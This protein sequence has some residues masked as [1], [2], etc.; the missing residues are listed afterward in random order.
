M[1]A[2]VIL[3]NVVR[4]LFGGAKQKARTNTWGRTDQESSQQHT[5]TSSS[6]RNARKGKKIFNSGEGEYVEFEEVKDWRLRQIFRLAF[7]EQ[8]LIEKINLR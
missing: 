4:R 3:L 5:H 2:P 6:T 7:L 8:R 1:L